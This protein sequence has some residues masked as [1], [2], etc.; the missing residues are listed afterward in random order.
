[1][2]TVKV[3]LGTCGLSA[4]DQLSIRI[5]LILDDTG[6]VTATTVAIKAVELV[7]T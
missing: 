1:M 3:G 5:D 6:G 4:G 7:V 2:K